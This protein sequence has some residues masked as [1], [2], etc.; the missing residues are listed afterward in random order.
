MKM[1]NAA[2]VKAINQAL[3][4]NSK[5]PYERPEIRPWQYVQMEYTRVGMSVPARMPEFETVDDAQIWMCLVLKSA[6]RKMVCASRL[7]SSTIIAL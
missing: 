3:L 2:T 5:E 7:G 4:F 1:M 6:G